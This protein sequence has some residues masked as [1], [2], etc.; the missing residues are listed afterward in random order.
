MTNGTFQYQ[1]LTSQFLKTTSFEGFERAVENGASLDLEILKMINGLE[2]SLDCQSY[3]PLLSIGGHFKKQMIS[4]TKLNLIVNI[5]SNNLVNRDVNLETINLTL[6]IGEV[7]PFT[8]IYIDLDCSYC[9]TRQRANIDGVRDDQHPCQETMKQEWT[10]AILAISRRVNELFG[11]KIECLITTKPTKPFCGSHLMFLVNIDV[12][13]KQMVMKDLYETC[14]FSRFILDKPTN[15]VLPLSRKHVKLHHLEYTNEDAPVIISKP[16]T[17]KSL[18]EFLYLD[19]YKYQHMNWVVEP[20]NIDKYVDSRS[21]MDE[22]DDLN[23]FFQIALY[24]EGEVVKML[25]FPTLDIKKCNDQNTYST[26]PFNINYDVFKFRDTKTSPEKVISKSLIQIQQ[27]KTTMKTISFVFDEEG[28][29]YQQCPLI[30][31]KRV[32]TIHFPL[33]K[34]QIL[35]D[36]MP[37][38]NLESI[39]H[40]L[41]FDGISFDDDDDDMMGGDDFFQFDAINQMDFSVRP[42]NQKA[43]V[44]EYIP[45]LN[46]KQTELEAIYDIYQNKSLRLKKNEA[47]EIEKAFRNDLEPFDKFLMIFMFQHSQQEKFTRVLNLLNL[48]A[49]D[50]EMKK[51][52]KPTAKKRK[53]DENQIMTDAMEKMLSD[54]CTNDNA[55]SSA[56]NLG[57]TPIDSIF[58]DEELALLDKIGFGLIYLIPKALFLGCTLATIAFLCRNTT[59]KLRRI[60]EILIHSFQEY[61]HE[62]CYF[63]MARLLSYDEEKMTNFL[64]SNFNGNPF[65]YILFQMEL[66]RKNS[67]TELA[68]IVIAKITQV[69]QTKIRTDVVMRFILKHILSVKK[70][71]EVYLVF[72]GECYRKQASKQQAKEMFEKTL[73]ITNILD[74]YE[75]PAYVPPVDSLNYTHFTSRGIYNALFGIYEP[76]TPSLNSLVMRLNDELH[77]KNLLTMTIT[78]RQYQFQKDVHFKIKHLIDMLHNNVLGFV[79]IAPTFCPKIPTSSYMKNPINFPITSSNTQVHDLNKAMKLDWDEDFLREVIE[80]GGIFGKY[81]QQF[82]GIMG[83]INQTYYIY[84]RS[85]MQFLFTFLGRLDYELAGAPKYRYKNNVFEFLTNQQEAFGK[86]DTESMEIDGIVDEIDPQ[87]FTKDVEISIFHSNLAKYIKSLTIK[88]VE[89]TLDSSIKQYQME[90]SY[91]HV[92]DK[93]KSHAVKCNF[94]DI[95]NSIELDD[96]FQFDFT[97]MNQEY[98][99]FCITIFSWIIRLGDVHSYMESEYFKGLY[100]ERQHVYDA[101]AAL[102]LKYYKNFKT[103]CLQDVADLIK[104]FHLEHELIYDNIKIE[105]RASV[106]IINWEAFDAESPLIKLLREKQPSPDTDYTEV[107]KDEYFLCCAYFLTFSNYNY[108][109][110][111][112]FTKMSG[113]IIYPGNF[114]KKFVNLYGRANAGKSGFVRMLQTAMETIDSEKSLS[115]RYSSSNNQENNVNAGVLGRSLLAVLDDPDRYLHATEIKNDVNITHV[116]TRNIHANDRELYYPTAKFFITSNDEVINRD[117]DDDGWNLR[118]YPIHL[119]HSFC[120]L[121]QVVSRITENNLDFTTDLLAFQLLTNK[122]PEQKAMNVANALALGIL[123]FYSK[124]Y[125]NTIESPISKTMTATVA[126]TKHRY[127][128]ITSPYYNFNHQVTTIVSEKPITIH[129]IS[130]IIGKWLST[131]PQ[132]ASSVK[133]LVSDLTSKVANDNNQY[134]TGSSKYT[135][136]FCY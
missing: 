124:F 72:N 118:M 101:F 80:T 63:T 1:T 25:F 26:I 135:I 97:N 81:F 125:F 121:K 23:N 14:H 120:A 85:P 5:L 100:S 77:K 114:N 88:N 132:F 104:K 54:G 24:K 99:K 42:E 89:V 109:N 65:M 122:Y 84:P 62:T 30:C 117:G 21:E 69:L 11:E 66:M 44:D 34:G 20:V 68:K 22:E 70:I 43:G 67:P 79:L 27:S 136:T 60:I 47:L 9:K 7:F 41:N 128:I 31:K 76:P 91:K 35:E 39:D 116:S 108:D 38:V 40:N 71:G 103:P 94:I 115:K 12:V 32:E 73:K 93:I 105:E 106:E 18:G 78:P 49:N 15:V 58:N 52:R 74:L 17:Y 102:V 56:S 6:A 123:N 51:K 64:C 134:H 130:E 92:S 87:E 48:E 29:Y 86:Q 57:E 129:E 113:G 55:N 2:S 98:L 16:W 133:N 8:R 82:M 61:T 28:E 50:L 19:V 83:C 13:I 90:S 46:F 110:Y 95:F 36:C 3:I 127:L 111:I 10:S 33:I 107:E 119:V 59:L 112:E 96:N 126:A 53:M 75:V 131:K 45:Y 4:P 37:P